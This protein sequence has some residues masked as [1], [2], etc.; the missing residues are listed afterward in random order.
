MKDRLFKITCF[1]YLTDSFDK[2]IPAS[3]IEQCLNEGVKSY[4]TSRSKRKFTVKEITRKK[5]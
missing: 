1:H 2:E 4:Y 5:K 3:E